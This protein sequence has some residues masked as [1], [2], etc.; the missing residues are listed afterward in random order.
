MKF[1]KMNTGEY[2]LTDA[3]TFFSVN[4]ETV[5]P[6]CH[7]MHI[8]FDTLLTEAKELSIGEL[9]FSI[10]LIIEKASCSGLINGK[11]DIEE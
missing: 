8:N 4:A 1:Y 3:T 2:Y 9:P 10:Q 7:S 6:I 11:I 5:R